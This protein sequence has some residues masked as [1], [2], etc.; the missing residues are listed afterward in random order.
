AGIDYLIF[1]GPLIDR[2]A[3]PV[4]QSFLAS[5][6][7][8]VS[9]E[10]VMRLFLMTLFVWISYK[11]KRTKEGK[12]TDVGVWSAIVLTSILFGAGHLPLAAT[13]TELTPSVVA[14]VIVLNGI[15][16]VTFGWLYWRKGLESAMISHFSADV[17][18]HVGL[19]LLTSI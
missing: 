10:V 6:Y 14:R 9:E 12:P 19:P 11:I 13:L 5:F 1:T 2:P 17:V 8:G 16:G 15:G 7:G 18:L 4:W 3:P